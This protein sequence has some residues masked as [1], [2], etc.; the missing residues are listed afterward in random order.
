MALWP[1][2]GGAISPATQEQMFCVPKHLLIG[3]VLPDQI[4]SDCKPEPKKF[5]RCPIVL[6]I[7]V[8]ELI[9]GDFGDLKAFGL[10]SLVP[11]DRFR[12]ALPK[13]PYGVGKGAVPE[14]HQGGLLTDPTA[15]D[16][17]LVESLAGKTFIFG[18]KD[19]STSC[20]L[21]K[22]SPGNAQIWSTGF[23]TRI[24]TELKKNK[25]GC[26]PLRPS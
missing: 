2:S 26:L 24:E 21:C 18:L 3:T 5:I 9:A 13:V 6:S 1:G 10:T 23:R 4:I 12:V 25:P 20:A 7:R 19:N 11:G 16:R 22:V 14:D 8:G 17:E 15:T